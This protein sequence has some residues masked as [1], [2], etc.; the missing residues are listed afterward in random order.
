M[1]GFETEVKL[2]I[3]L[4]Q[5]DSIPIKV[6]GNCNWHPSCITL[7]TLEFRNMDGCRDADSLY[8]VPTK[9]APSGR[10]LGRTER[11]GLGFYHCSRH[12]I[13]IQVLIGII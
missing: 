11:K 10:V 1:Y 12:D 13:G 4:Q 5:S 8:R 9:G 2:L 3:P 6:I 7:V